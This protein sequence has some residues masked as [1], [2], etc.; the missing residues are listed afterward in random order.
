MGF[1]FD[2]TACHFLEEGGSEEPEWDMQTEIDETKLEN[3][4]PFQIEGVRF[5]EARQ[6][7][8]IISDQMGLGKTIEALGYLKL[9]LEMRP[10][11]IVCPASLKLNWKAEFKRWLS[12]PPGAETKD[13]L[14]AFLCIKSRSGLA[15]N[16]TAL[17][18]F[19]TLENRYRQATGRTTEVR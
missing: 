14:C 2:V 15:A 5:L 3:F 17:A 6:G 9:H 4:Y 12:V 16:D 10:A 1:Q 7:N 13:V 19:L 8:G 18:K 11:L